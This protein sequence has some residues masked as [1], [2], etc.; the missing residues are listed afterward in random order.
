MRTASVTGRIVT[1]RI[2]DDGK[3]RK[4]AASAF[5]V[6]RAVYAIKFTKT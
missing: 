1:G 3:R 2:R 4:P 6:L 5:P